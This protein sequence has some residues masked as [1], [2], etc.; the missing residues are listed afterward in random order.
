MPGR[1]PEEVEMV[2]SKCAPVSSGDCIAAA[3]SSS[4]FPVAT[5]I[6]STVL[7]FSFDLLFSVPKVILSR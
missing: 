5:S 7:E 3:N 6:P 4:R 1:T 2:S